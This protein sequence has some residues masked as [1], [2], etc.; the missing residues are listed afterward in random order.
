[1]RRE[2][3]VDAAAMWGM[4]AV[5]FASPARA[6]LRREVQSTTTGAAV[7]SRPAR[8]KTGVSVCGPIK[9]FSFCA[10]TG[11]SLIKV[12]AQRHSFPGGS[13]LANKI[14]CTAASDHASFT[15]DTIKRERAAARLHNPCKKHAAKAKLAANRIGSR[16]R[17]PKQLLQHRDA[18]ARHTR[19]SVQ[20]IAR[21]NLLHGARASRHRARA[22]SVAINSNPV[23]PPPRRRRRRRRANSDINALEW[24]SRA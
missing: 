9:S 6:D 4:L 14:L 18:G 5:A 16:G 11:I 19:C 15:P 7:T 1:M 24:S 22:G 10:G 17:V 8:E 3:V 21:C 13:D 2:A 23:C 12:V 20:T